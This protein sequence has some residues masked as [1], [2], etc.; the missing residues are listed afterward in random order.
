MSA[1]RQIR[2]A[3]RDDGWWPLFW[4][5][6]WWQLTDGRTKRFPPDG[7]VGQVSTSSQDIAPSRWSLTSTH[8][9]RLQRTQITSGARLWRLTSEWETYQPALPPSRSGLRLGSTSK[10]EVANGEEG[11]PPQTLITSRYI[12]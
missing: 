9:S 1:Y 2:V 4:L 10:H 12:L 7:H 11:S 5:R 3:W 8:L 6:L